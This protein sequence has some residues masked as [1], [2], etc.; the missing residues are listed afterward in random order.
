MPSS[1]SQWHP[2]PTSSS[3]SRRTPT[4]TRQHTARKTCWR[5]R[6]HR[7]HSPPAASSASSSGG[8]RQRMRAWCPSPSTAGPQ[9]QEASPTSTLSTSP[10][11]ALISRMSASSSHCP[12]GRPQSTSATASGGTTRA[13]PP[14]CGTSSSSTT[15]T[16]AAP[17]SLWW[18][19]PTRTRS[20]PWRLA[21]PRTRRSATSRSSR[22]RTR[23]RT[24]R[25]SSRPRRC[26]PLPTT[27]WSKQ[28][29]WRQWLGATC[30]SSSKAGQAQLHM[31]PAPASSYSQKTGCRHTGAP[32]GAGCRRATVVSAWSWVYRCGGG[33]AQGLW[34]SRVNCGCPAVIG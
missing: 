32:A 11:P 24:C 22:S 14:L 29:P 4:S 9:C 28:Q 10:Q 25:S 7:D 1:V 16:A 17:W 31:A 2:G 27:W 21:S 5:S 18:A 19:R 8:C 34:G 23:R 15:P 30:S 13:A 12:T 6:T 20:T 33:G 26:W 3:S